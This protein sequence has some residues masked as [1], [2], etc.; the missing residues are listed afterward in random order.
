[1]SGAAHQQLNLK[2][3]ACVFTLSVIAEA[4]LR[5]AETNRVFSSADSIEFFEF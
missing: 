5:L 2:R 3:A 1:M 4:H